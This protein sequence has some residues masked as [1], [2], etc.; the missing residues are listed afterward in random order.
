MQIP[1]ECVYI[2]LFHLTRKTSWLYSFFVAKQIRSHN[3]IHNNQEVLNYQYTTVP[4][5][6]MI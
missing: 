5:L 4:K 3:D 6:C 2:F 1:G